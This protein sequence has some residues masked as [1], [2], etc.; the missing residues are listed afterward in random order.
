MNRPKMILFD[1]GKTLI[2]YI[3][4]ADNNG[5]LYLS[6]M[7]ATE[8]LMQYIVSN[9]N[10][11]DA[12]AID[13]VNNEVFEKYNK[14]RETLYEINNQKILKLI[15]DLLNIE[16]SISFAEV[17]RIIWENSANIV[18][19]EGTRE[20]L[21]QLKNLHIRTA[22]ISNLDFSGY[23]LEERLNCLLPNNE[24]EYVIAS[25]DYGI[26]K[27]QNLIFEVGIAKSGL[28]AEEIW[29][30]GDKLKV[31]VTGSRAEGMTP[32]LFKSKRNAYSDIPDDVVVIENFAQLVDLLKNI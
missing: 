32:V 20:L 28:S 2:D 16:L 26:R 17:E 31:D 24:F 3:P 4:K 22:V 9:P 8:K 21:D 6:T 13:R 23:L 27:P 5:M 30:I 15:F 7:D 18:P 10:H 11:Y 1:A 12:A 19:V 25:S 14:C 29:Y